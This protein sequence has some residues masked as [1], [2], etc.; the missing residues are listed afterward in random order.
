VRVTILTQYS[1]VCQTPGAEPYTVCAY[2][3]TD[4]S[5]VLG[6]TQA[7]RMHEGSYG[8]MQECG[9]AVC[10]DRSLDF[11]RDDRRIKSAW[12]KH[13]LLCGDVG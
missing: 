11:A 4:L 12:G 3:G 2:S 8:W 7:D 13:S 5:Q 6:I 10:F 9:E 1:I